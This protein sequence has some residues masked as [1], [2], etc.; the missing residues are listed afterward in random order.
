ME[1]PSGFYC[2]IFVNEKEIYS[3][4]LREV[5]E[6]FR[7][8]MVR[9]LTEWAETLGKRGLNELIYSHLAWY[10]EKTVYCGRCGNSLEGTSTG[11]CG[12]CGGKPVER[13]V[14]ERDK[15]LDM[16]ITCVGMITKVQVSKI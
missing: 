13:Y 15:S 16:I 12:E 5:P 1:E 11:V 3:G 8:R 7:L 4:E 9:D 2:T 10:E 14:H 6:E